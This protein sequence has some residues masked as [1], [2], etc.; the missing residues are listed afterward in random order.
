MARNKSEEM[1]VAQG[2][3]HLLLYCHSPMDD[4]ELALLVPWDQAFADICVRSWR[5]LEQLKKEDPGIISIRRQSEDHQAFHAAGPLLQWL[6]DNNQHDAFLEGV[7]I[8]ETPPPTESWPRAETHA[9][10]LTFAPRWVFWETYELHSDGA[11][12]SGTGIGQE[13]EVLFG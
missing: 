10:I 4:D 1:P 6:H 12:E 2:A 9:T 5:R 8:C 3:T 11:F 13:N 7:A